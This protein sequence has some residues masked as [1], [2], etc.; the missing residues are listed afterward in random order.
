MRQAMCHGLVLGVDGGEI[1]VTAKVPFPLLDLGLGLCWTGT[2]TQACLNT[3][4]VEIIQ[5]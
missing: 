5:G 2:R 4:T 3:K 1:L